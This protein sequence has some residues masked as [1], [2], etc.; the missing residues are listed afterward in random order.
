MRRELVAV[1]IVAHV[2]VVSVRCSVVVAPGPLGQ[3]PGGQSSAAKD[4]SPANFSEQEKA[5]SACIHLRKK[6]ARLESRGERST[7]LQPVPSS[8]TAPEASIKAAPAKDVS[9]SECVA[10]KS[11]N[12]NAHSQRML[13]RL[14]PTSGGERTK[15][16]F[17]VLHLC[18]GPCAQGTPGCDQ[19]MLKA[20]LI[21]GKAVQT[22]PN[23]MWLPTND[24]LLHFSPASQE[25]SKVA[26][27]TLPSGHV[28]TQFYQNDS[29]R[30]FGRCSAGHGERQPESQWRAACKTVGCGKVKLG[31]LDFAI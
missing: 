24:G 9:R 15:T 18:N 10:S 27:I 22:S 21:E 14:V 30:L 6:L 17:D 25:L 5:L 19:E 8:T 1:A 20:Q 16:S 7:R 2:I 23:D 31:L 13:E 29:K 4:P 11:T 26:N 12:V 3:S 28:E